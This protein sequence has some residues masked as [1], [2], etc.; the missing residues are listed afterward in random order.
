VG[1]NGGISTTAPGSCDQACVDLGSAGLYLKLFTLHGRL[2]LAVYAVA[3]SPDGTLVA[4]GSEDKSARVFEARTGREVARL[5][6][7]EPVRRVDL[8]SGGR[9]LRAVSGEVDLRI[10]KDLIRVSDLIAEACSKLDRNLTRE[11]WAIY[12]G[13]LPYRESCQ[14][15]NPGVV[16]KRK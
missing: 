11:E 3:F 8:V 16:G 7:G 10:T 15:L 1:S 2:S 12:L 13:G 4:T 9:S 6:L 14:Q 5:A